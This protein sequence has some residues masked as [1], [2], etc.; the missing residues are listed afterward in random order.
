MACDLAHPVCET[1]PRS[2]HIV[3]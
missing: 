1:S 2:L 3:T